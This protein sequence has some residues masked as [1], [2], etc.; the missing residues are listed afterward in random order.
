VAAE[1][2]GVAQSDGAHVIINSSDVMLGK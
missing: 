1:N 2:L